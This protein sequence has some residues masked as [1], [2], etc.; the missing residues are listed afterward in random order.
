MTNH[1]KNGFQT[2]IHE[3]ITTTMVLP[4]SISN[5]GGM[6]QPGAPEPSMAGWV[7]W[8]ALDGELD[9]EIDF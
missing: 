5:I 8:D 7:L 2:D 4:T 3:R 1:P 6:D 9:G